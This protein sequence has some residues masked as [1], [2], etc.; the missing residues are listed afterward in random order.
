MT[1]SMISAISVSGASSEVISGVKAH[2][3]VREDATTGANMRLAPAVAASAGD[4]PA[5]NCVR[6]SSPT[7]MA[8]STTMPKAMMKPIKLTAL[9]VPPR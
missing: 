7:T 2:S 4:L 6:A 3:V 1:T 9:M 8:S 5:S